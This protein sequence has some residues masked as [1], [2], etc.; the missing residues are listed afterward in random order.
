[1]SGEVDQAALAT[2]RERETASTTRGNGRVEELESELEKVRNELA[3]LRT[4]FDAFK[5]QFG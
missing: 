5:E 2:G 4:E 1:L 3:D